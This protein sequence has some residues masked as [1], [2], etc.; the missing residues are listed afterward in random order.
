MCKDCLPFRDCSINS[1]EVMRVESMRE[2]GN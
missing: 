2:R 1:N